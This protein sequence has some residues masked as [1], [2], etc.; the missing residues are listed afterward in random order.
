[1]LPYLPDSVRNPVKVFREHVAPF[2]DSAFLSFGAGSAP[3]TLKV[4]TGEGGIQDPARPT[5]PWVVV[6]DRRTPRN[7]M[8]PDA[9]NPAPIQGQGRLLVLVLPVGH[10]IGGGDS[11]RLAGRFADSLGNSSVGS[12]VWVPIRFGA[13]P[14]RVI[15]RDQDGDGQVDDI[16]I[17]LTKSSAGVPTP[18]GFGMI[19]NGT[20]KTIAALTRSQ[21]LLSWRGSIGPYAL[22]TAPLPGDAGWLAMG[23]DASTFRSAVE[24]SVA[25]VAL[26]ARLIYGFDAGSW[27]TLEITG[28]EPLAIQA[29]SQAMVASDPAGVSRIVSSAKASVVGGNV[30]RIA[31]PAGSI[32]DD[33]LWARLGTG[34][35][36]GH[37]SVGAVSRWVPLVVV[38][39]GR[40]TLFDSDGDGRADSIHLAM[41]G[42]MPLAWMSVSWCGT[43]GEP[44]VRKWPVAA[45]AGASGIR[46][47]DPTA[48][49]AKGATSC[50]QDPSVTFL[51][52]G[53]GAVLARW[54]LLDGVAPMVV[55]AR[56]AFGD[57]ADTLVVRFSEPV[58]VSHATPPWVEWKGSEPTP[59]MHDP[60]SMLGGDGTTAMLVLR[61]GSQATDL[62]DSVRIASGSFAGNLADQAGVFAGARS[63]MAPLEWGLP[64]LS[65]AVSDPQ[66]LGRGTTVSVRA[67]R[68]VPRGAIAGV[69]KVSIRWNGEGRD[70]PM[71]DLLPAASGGWLGPLASPLAL[72]STHCGEDCGASSVSALGT[73]APAILVDSVPP[74]LVAASFRYSKR[75]VARDTLFFQVSEP[76]T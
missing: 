28:S 72:G 53:T 22:S 55:Q 16:E 45:H 27:D 35:S 62:T 18:T 25:P 14:V 8:V 69:W 70:V 46:P 68:D 11:V 9:A 29:S 52:P 47:S 13:Q 39:S 75:D 26:S 71:A 31:V 21:D 48:W 4:W 51:D 41:R 32:P 20:P 42:S 17:R 60:A 7:L 12:S 54:P 58:G 66:G 43:T 37:A 3:D 74:S 19:W 2:A 33:V 44:D 36:D 10:G 15:A 56:Y 63:P 50:L 57:P 23:A 49:F 5:S 6:G 73:S 24:D 59:V 64:P 1:T 34:V 40:A 76:W 65:V 67:L 30:L 61:S 38:P